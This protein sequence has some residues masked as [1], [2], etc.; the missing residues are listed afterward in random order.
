MYRNNVEIHVLIKGK[1][2]PEYPHNGDLFIEGREGSNFE[3]EITNRNPF[4]VEAIISVDGLSIVDGREAGTE[5][6]GYLVD[7]HSTVR[8]PGWKLSD[9]QVAAFFFSGKKQSYATQT[10]GSSRNNGVIGAMIFASKRQR[11]WKTQA[12]TD[13]KYS[14]GLHMSGRN[15]ILRASPSWHGSGLVASTS[16]SS[17]SAHNSGPFADAVLSGN[18][19]TGFGHA[20]TYVTHTVNFERGDMLAVMYLYYDDAKGLRA[21]GVEMGRRTRQV[22]KP[23]A[24]PAMACKPPQGWNG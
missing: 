16:T 21:R 7:A 4:D 6:S 15:S 10:T 9:E 12:I 24:F 14:S 22:V 11:E 23:Q 3:I 18:I 13:Q 5:S 20:E 2:I 8:I 17:L 19:G 1:T